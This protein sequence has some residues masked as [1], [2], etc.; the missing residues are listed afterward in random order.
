MTMDVKLAGDVQ[1]EQVTEEL[2]LTCAVTEL[3]APNYDVILPTDV[4]DELP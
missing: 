1:C 4:V 2:Q 3:N